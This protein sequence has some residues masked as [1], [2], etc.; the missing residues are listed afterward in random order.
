MWG[1]PTK[2]GKYA[3]GMTEGLEYCIYGF[4]IENRVAHSIHWHW[5]TRSL[6]IHCEELFMI[7]PC[8]VDVWLWV[9]TYY[10]QRIKHGWLEN[11]L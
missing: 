7:F 9:K 6:T 5:E 4:E 1:N 10:L 2:K 8:L 11:P 3:N